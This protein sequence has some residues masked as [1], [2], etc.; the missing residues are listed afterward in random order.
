M[1]NPLLKSIVTAAVAGVL[2]AI[3]QHFAPG[4]GSAVVGASGAAATALFMQPPTT[5]K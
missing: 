1:N 5:K 2:Q 3:L 4:V